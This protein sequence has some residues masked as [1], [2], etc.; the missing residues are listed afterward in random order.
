LTIDFEL[1]EHNRRVDHGG[2]EGQRD[3]VQETLRH[4][5]L[6][7][8]PQEAHLSMPIRAARRFC[9]LDLRSA[10]LVGLELTIGG[11]RVLRVNPR[12]SPDD[13][14]LL[15]AQPVYEDAKGLIDETLSR[16]D[17]QRRSGDARLNAEN[18]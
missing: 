15:R 9:V 4:R 16:R 7:H 8:R 2:G 17:R 12:D 11:Q 13:K 14:R 1:E 6:G 5:V 3:I 10:S 18:R